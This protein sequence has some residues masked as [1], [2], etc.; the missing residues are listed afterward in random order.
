[1]LPGELHKL[2][3][4]DA[5]AVAQPFRDVSNVA[6]ASDIFVSDSIINPG[7]KGLSISAA[8]HAQ[9]GES[10]LWGIQPMVFGFDFRHVLGH[11]PSLLVLSVVIINV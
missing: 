5:S 4:L 7:H 2:K 1:M 11:L 9:S 10:W 8:V 6:R 3:R